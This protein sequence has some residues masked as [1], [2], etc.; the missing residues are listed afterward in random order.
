MTALMTSLFREVYL[1]ETESLL[2]TYIGMARHNNA[3]VNGIVDRKIGDQDNAFVDI[4]GMGGELAAARIFGAY[5]DLTIVAADSL[6]GYDFRSRSGLRVDVKTTEWPNGKLLATLKTKVEDADMYVLVTG[7]IPRYQVIGYATADQL[8]R[9]ENIGRLKSDL[10]EGYILG[11]DS[12]TLLKPP[13][14]S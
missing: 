3:R 6:P 9:E 12:M 11:R 8:I 4:N 13:A 14:E 7:V 2:A 5:P 1:N 10:E